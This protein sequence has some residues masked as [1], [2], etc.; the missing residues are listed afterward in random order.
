VWRTCIRSD[1]RVPIVRVFRFAAAVSCSVRAMLDTC[2]VHDCAA[3]LFSVRFA[4]ASR[5]TRALRRHEKLAASASN[6]AAR[7][8]VRL[9]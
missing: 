5:N 9:S 8:V 3:I 1:R 7:N 2:A 4:C 6:F